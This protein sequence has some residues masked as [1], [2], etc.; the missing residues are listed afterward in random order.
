ML[1]IAKDTLIVNH[2]GETVK[3]EELT[4]GAKVIGFYSPMLTRSL[5][6]IGTAWKVVVETPAAE[7][8]AK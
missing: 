7:L 3:A 4:K 6:P 5:P 1:N 8:E 2:E